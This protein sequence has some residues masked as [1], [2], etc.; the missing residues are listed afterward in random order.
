VEIELTKLKTAPH[1][2][3]A[4]KRFTAQARLTVSPGATPAGLQLR[5]M[6]R[7][8]DSR[9]RVVRRSMTDGVARCTW[10]VPQ[11]AAGQRLRATV[12]AS[13]AGEILQRRFSRRVRR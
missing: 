2:P 8:S 12:E 9:L 11:D 6:A 7:V 13:V 1:V 5:C 3:R 10:L 4:G